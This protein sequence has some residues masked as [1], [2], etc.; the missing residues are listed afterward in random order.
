[1]SLKKR[2]IT[3]MITCFVV[4]GINIMTVNAMDQEGVLPPF[5]NTQRIEN[6]VKKV[7]E[8][9]GHLYTAEEKKEII[10]L[11][12]TYNSLQSEQ[13]PQTKYLEQP[14]VGSSGYKLGVLNS[15]TIENATKN[16]NYYRQIARL[17]DVVTTSDPLEWSQYAAVGMAATRDQSHGLINSTKPEYMEKKFWEK[18]VNYSNKSLLHS[19]YQERSLND[20]TKA[21]LAD[22][23]SGNKQ[24][25]HRSWLLSH[26]IGEIGFG[27]A[28]AE[29]PTSTK[30]ANYYNAMYIYDT[31]NKT[32]PKET[33][34]TWPSEGVFPI[35]LMNNEDRPEESLRWS[36]H[37]DTRGYQ[38]SD[39]TTVKITHKET[40]ETWS[41]SKNSSEGAFLISP[42]KAGGHTNIMFQPGTEAKPFTYDVGDIFSV[43]I[44]GIT[45][46]AT[47]YTYDVRLFDIM[48]KLPDIEIDS[49]A[50]ST[51]KIDLKI[52]ETASINATILPEEATDKSLRWSTS[53]ESIATV[54]QEGK[55]T[56]ISEG[57]VTISSQS[58]SGNATQ[59]LILTIAPIKAERIGYL[60][61]NYGNIPVGG[62]LQI[63]G[64]VEA[65]YN[66]SNKEVIYK[67][68][69]KDEG[70]ITVSETGLVTGIKTGMY[71]LEIMSADGGAREKN[72]SISVGS[73]HWM[74]ATGFPVYLGG[75]P[76]TPIPVS[77]VQFNQS[78]LTGI[79][80]STWSL[81]S[82]VSPTNASNTYRRYRS[83]DPTI[84]KVLNRDS[85]ELV[86]LKKGVATITVF[87][88]DG[89]YEDTL[90][91]TVN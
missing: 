64:Y 7:K 51:D 63:N 32:I 89:L 78:N 9:T 70:K 91:V 46:A 58:L 43:Q 24:V 2:A 23:G 84:V 87:T 25:G 56:A 73:G 82:T 19:S 88:A 10:A 67:I 76:L 81:T 59:S 85:G 18:A 40:K 30:Q 26:E 72:V 22:Y 4:S 34:T 36:A 50:L 86:A 47:S 75:T 69:P 68:Q 31:T 16:L 39:E 71:Y 35:D 66:V 42:N 57:S 52:G 90:Q 45:G 48:E 12:Q 62:T 41:F 27:Y 1:M 54:D 49:I 5:E 44:E 13:L 55:V 6:G 29:N 28:P 79:E 15:E 21:Y 20:H 65:P 14:L 80:G 38:V 83:D 17:S 11:Q 74:T 60:L 77:G 3:L 53:D 8:S 61:S 37:L 33:I